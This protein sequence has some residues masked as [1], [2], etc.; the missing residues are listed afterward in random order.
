MAAT[1]GRSATP[2]TL[3]FPYNLKYEVNPE[4]GEK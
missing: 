2:R 3:P 1:E 4:E